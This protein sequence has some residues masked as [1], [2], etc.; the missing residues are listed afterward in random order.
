MSEARDPCGY[1][2]ELAAAQ[3]HIAR[4]E[5]ELARVGAAS[6]DGDRARALDASHD[7]ALAAVGPELSRAGGLVAGLIIG[8]IGG[9]CV[10]A[11]GKARA[12][13]VSIY[14]LLAVVTAAALSSALYGLISNVA[15]KAAR[16]EL[17]KAWGPRAETTLLARRRRIGRGKEALS[18]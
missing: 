12:V 14:L 7:R 11:L 17:E 10:G 15:S 2:D 18:P 4:L 8:L 1:R 5:D 16:I 6:G 13:D 3:M 9:V